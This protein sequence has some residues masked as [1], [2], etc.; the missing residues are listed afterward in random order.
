[1]KRPSFSVDTA[2]GGMKPPKKSGA[3][4]PPGKP[5]VATSGKKKKAVRGC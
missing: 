2:M 4:K 5:N 3:M 1:M